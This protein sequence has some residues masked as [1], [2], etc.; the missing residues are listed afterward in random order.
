M[1]QTEVVWIYEM[2]LRVT[3]SYSGSTGAQ[4]PSFYALTTLFPSISSY[5]QSHTRA[6]KQDGDSNDDPIFSPTHFHS[7][8]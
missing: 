8:K 2:D 5:K 4:H 3:P 7:V 1:I 6:D